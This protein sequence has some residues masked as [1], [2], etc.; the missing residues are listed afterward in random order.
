MYSDKYS[1]G[2]KIYI[3]TVIVTLAKEHTSENS[4]KAENAQGELKHCMR[5]YK[6]NEI[7]E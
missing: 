5:L 7:K 4:N 1:H 6:K 2:T 3:L